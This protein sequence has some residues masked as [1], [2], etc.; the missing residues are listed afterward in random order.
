MVTLILLV[1]QLR[2]EKPHTNDFIISLNIQTLRLL[3]TCCNNLF[4][5]IYTYIFIWPRDFTQSGLHLVTTGT[6]MLLDEVYRESEGT[7]RTW[8]HELI[9]AWIR[10]LM[11]GKR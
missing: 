7:E 10:R 11:N 2:C 9:C 3:Q 1:L 8:H 5:F 4:Y 6:G